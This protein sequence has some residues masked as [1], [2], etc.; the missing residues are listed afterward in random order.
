MRRRISITDEP[1]NNWRVHLQ[2]RTDLDGDGRFWE[3][4]NGN[5][6]VDIGEM[7]E[8]EYIRFTYGYNTGPTQQ[9]RISNPLERMA[10]GI[11]L[12]F[13]HRNQVDEVPTTDLTVEASFWK[14]TYWPWIRL[15]QWSLVIPPHG[16]ATFR[17]TFTV[18]RFAAHGMYEGSILARYGD[19]EVVIPVTAAVAARGTRFNIGF[20]DKPSLPFL[21]CNNSHRQRSVDPAD[22]LRH[23]HRGGVRP[24]AGGPTRHPAPPGEGGRHSPGG[25]VR[26]CSG[27]GDGGSRRSQRQR[28]C[29]YRLDEGHHQQRA[30]VTSLHC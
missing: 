15:S 30:G 2:N 6:K 26:G 17:A 16:S 14:R 3:D 13:R 11:L 20:L 4:T 23:Q 12:T 10:D 27:H 8:N 28:P 9:V 18:P 5:G 22:F 1:F 7:D 19:K 25:V 29:R 24:R 21:L